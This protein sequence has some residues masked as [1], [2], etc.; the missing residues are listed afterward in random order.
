MSLISAQTGKAIHYIQCP[1]QCTAKICC[2]GWG[3]NFT[4][5]KSARARLDVLAANINSDDILNRESQVSDAEAPLDLP[6]DLA[7]LDVEG[8][9]PKLSVLPARDRE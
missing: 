3:L 7:F 8:I 5:V 1:K 2:I 4:D 9:L 6:T